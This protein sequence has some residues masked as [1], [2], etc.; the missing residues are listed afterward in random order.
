MLGYRNKTMKI[1]Q[2]Q[3]QPKRTTVTLTREE[4][5]N[6][7]QEYIVKNSTGS[8]PEG[9]VTMLVMDSNSTCVRRFQTKD[10]VSFVIE[11]PLE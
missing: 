6:A 4:V 3:P 8:I 9:K 10:T 1:R 5:E 11:E 7:L 2:P